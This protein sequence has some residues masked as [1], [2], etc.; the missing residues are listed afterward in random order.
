MYNKAIL[1]SACVSNIPLQ[2][3]TRYRQLLSGASGADWHRVRVTRVSDPGPTVS[4][5]ISRVAV[6]C[7]LDPRA[8]HNS[9][10]VGV[11]VKN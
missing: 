7:G 4:T 5:I 8:S 6:R 3:T 2:G 10:A 1:Y 9:T 11:M